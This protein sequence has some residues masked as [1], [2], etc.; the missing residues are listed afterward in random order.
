MVDVNGVRHHLLLGKTDWARA[1]SGVDTR[2]VVYEKGHHVVTLRPLTFVFPPPVGDRT[3]DPSDRRGAARDQYGHWY[4]IGPDEHSVRVRWSGAHGADHYWSARDAQT[5]DAPEG[6][7][8]TPVAPPAPRPSERLAGLA[9]TSEHYLVVGAPESGSLLV[10]DLHTGGQPVRVRLPTPPG[11]SGQVTE[12]F[13]LAPLPDGG[14]LVLDSLHRLVWRLD[15]TFRPL[16]GPTLTAGPALVFQPVAGPARQGPSGGQPVPLDLSGTTDP[17]AVEPLPDGSLLILDRARAGVA[18]VWRFDG[19]ESQDVALA[20]PRDDLFG[21]DLALLPRTG[22]PGSAGTLYLVD[23]AGNQ[24]FGYDLEL[25]GTFSLTEQRRYLPLRSCTGKA[26]VVPPGASHAYFDQGDRWLRVVSLDRP[27][28]VGEGGVTLPVFDGRDPGCVWHR[29]CVDACLPAG[30]GLDVETRAADEP[31]L[32]DTQRWQRQPAP[33]LRDGGAEIPYYRLWS[34]EELGHASTGT[35]ELL[36]QR[37]SGRYLQVRLTLRGDGRTTP[38]IR[39]LRAHYPRFSYL[40][41]YL[42]SPYQD[43]PA[44]AEL[45]ET[46]LANPE[47]LLT[48]LEG[49][50]AEARANLDVRMVPP[51]ALE[52]LADWIGLALE[53]GWNEAQRRLMLAHA[54]ALYLR[55]GTLTGLAWALRLAL[56]ASANPAIFADEYEAC[57]GSIRI[58][59][60]FQTRRF[61]AVAVGDPTELTAPTGAVLDIARERAH[62]FTVLLPADLGPAE[63]AL[64]ERVIDAQKPAHTHVVVKRYWDLFRVGEARLGLDSRLGPAGRFAPFLLGETALAEGALGAAYPEDLDLAGRRV[65]AP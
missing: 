1:L 23:T 2:E 20:L 44:S 63:R 4:W 60:R 28:Y 47:G 58:V 21:H 48:T 50:L 32:L 56:D 11:P 33:Y 46:F 64:V 59:E 5:C 45:L 55:R 19:D 40:R 49:K 9:V 8:F 16:P 18:T 26:L 35:W 41:Q 53:P 51:D 30:T 57:G 43:D 6:G 65:V 62:R 13:D 36:F 15:A 22:D 29:L 27:R 61:A 24:A 39:A 17:I 12:P 10:F 38:R 42:P 7:L 37:A 14:L 54:P 25:A 3:F 31:G 52:W 34:R